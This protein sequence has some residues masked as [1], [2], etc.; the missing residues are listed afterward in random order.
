MK[1]DEINLFGVDFLPKNLAPQELTWDWYG[2]GE[3][4]VQAMTQ[5]HCIQRRCP[6]ISHTSAGVCCNPYPG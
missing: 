1:H 6:D 5:G 3:K 4:I 2:C